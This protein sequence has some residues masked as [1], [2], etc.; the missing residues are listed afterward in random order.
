MRG[1][2]RQQQRTGSRVE[3]GGIV[4]RPPL[5]GPAQKGAL[6]FL[7]G[8]GVVVVV[9]VEF[10]RYSTFFFRFQLLAQR[11][12]GLVRLPTR[13]RR[14]RLMVQNLVPQVLHLL[15][16]T[17]EHLPQFHNAHLQVGVV[18]QNVPDEAGDDVVVAVGATQFLRRGGAFESARSAIELAFD[19]ASPLHA[20]D[21]IGLSIAFF[22]RLLLNTVDLVVQV[23]QGTFG[24]PPAL[25]G[26]FG[27]FVRR[28]ETLLQLGLLGL[29]LREL[30]FELGG[31]GRG[32]GQFAELRLGALQGDGERLGAGVRLV[33]GLVQVLQLLQ[34]IA[35]LGDDAGIFRLGLE[36]LALEAFHGEQQPMAVLLCL[37]HVG[38]MA[39]EKSL[40]R[41]G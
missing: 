2:P 41:K 37:C 1:S 38:F 25:H 26:G 21:E 7:D 36:F 32:D 6:F 23:A 40:E 11:G 27:V 13:V 33:D 3:M 24:F 15:I 12:G 20:L 9:D 5:L 14:H 4:P 29:H 39:M 35:V 10:P 19:G 17:L 30:G 22:A 31:A 34:E 28:L 18:L 8:W 16:G